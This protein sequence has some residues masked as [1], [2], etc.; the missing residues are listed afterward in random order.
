MNAVP[1]PQLT[2]GQ[3][4]RTWTDAQRAEQARLLRSRQIWL[5][6]TG[7]RTAKGKI[8][9]SRN[10][11][12]IHYEENQTTN[13]IHHYIQTQ[14]HF[15][16]LLISIYKS[17]TD[18]SPADRNFHTQKILILNNEL[19]EMHRDLMAHLDKMPPDTAKIIPFATTSPPS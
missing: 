1:K 18:M 13:K 8:T 16:K 3:G 9:S 12:G 5:K 17:W 4:Q 2:R 19:R 10:A 15:R 6:S 11:R 7:P 14:K